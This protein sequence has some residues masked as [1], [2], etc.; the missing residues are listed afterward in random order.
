MWVSMSPLCHPLKAEHKADNDGI[1]DSKESCIPEPGYTFGGTFDYSMG[2]YASPVGA[3]INLSTE[4]DRVA[5]QGGQVEPSGKPYITGY[6]ETGDLTSFS[7]IY[8]TPVKLQMT[9][10]CNIRINYYDALGA[11]SNVAN[12]FNE[13]NVTLNTLQGTF[14]T[15]HPLTAADKLTLSQNKWI[16][17]TFKIPV[18]LKFITFNRETKTRNR[19]EFKWHGYLKGH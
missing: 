14:T 2:R 17:V 3:S 10:S 1:L 16:S 9:S 11:A 6:D 5:Q 8:T 13:I 7:F 12:Y 4:A 15:V 18:P 19:Y